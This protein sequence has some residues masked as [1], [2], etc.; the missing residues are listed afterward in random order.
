MPRTHARILCSIWRD[1]EFVALSPAEQRMYL[2]LLSQPDLS[3]CGALVWRPKRWARLAP[4]E[5]VASVETAIQGLSERGYVMVDDEHDE[6]WIRSFIRYDGLL[7]QPNMVKA[8][9]S[10]FDQLMSKPIREAFQKEFEKALPEGRGVG[11]D[12]GEGV[13]RAESKNRA[14]QIVEALRAGKA[15]DLH[16]E[17]FM[18]GA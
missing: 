14:R 7:K 2:L 17:P 4:G 1:D 15:A 9:W 3:L 6:L 8:M 18:E 10:A 5:T 13:G 12:T 11:V 16:S